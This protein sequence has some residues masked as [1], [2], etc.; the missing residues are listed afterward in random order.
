M[1]TIRFAA[2]FAFAL[3]LP[4]TVT[5]CGSSEPGA[6]G[7]ATDKG[8][9]GSSEG[10]AP[11]AGG[12]KLMDLPLTVHA[13]PGAVANEG[14]PGF[15]SADESIYVMVKPL[16]TADP[17]D[18]A[19]VKKSTEE[20]MFKKWVKSEKTADGWVLIWV[21]IGMD[22]SGKEYDSH[23][24]SVRRKIGY[25]TYDCYGGV[26]KQADVEKNIKLCQAF[27]EAP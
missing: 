6:T 24:F 18:M 2:A 9:E 22:M 14:A 27:K 25:T 15:H 1:N 16:G 10:S 4:L 23:S 3:S 20:M 21:G 19:V 5:A 26:K 8:A 13:P 11:A 12:T 17:T 7:S